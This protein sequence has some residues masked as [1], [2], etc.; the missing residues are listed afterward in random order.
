MAVEWKEAE[1]YFPDFLEKKAYLFYTER[2][3]DP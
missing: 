3:S 2:V 1:F